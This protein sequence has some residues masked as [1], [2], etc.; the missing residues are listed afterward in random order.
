MKHRLL[1]GLLLLPLLAQADALGA[2]GAYYELLMW[3]YIAG[4]LLFIALV[5]YLLNRY[6]ARQRDREWNGVT[7]REKTSTHLLRNVVLGALAVTIVVFGLLLFA[8]Q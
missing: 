7:A 8:E 4:I 3:L 1:L 2:L 6:V 5:V